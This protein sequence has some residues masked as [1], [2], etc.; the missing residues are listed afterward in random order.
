M[1]G[2]VVGSCDSETHQQ[3]IQEGEEITVCWPAFLGK[4]IF[5]IDGRPGLASDTSIHTA[6]GEG[7]PSNR[8]IGIGINLDPFRGHKEPRAVPSSPL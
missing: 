1:V 8:S 2:I 6:P 3:S 7:R 5:C 4:R